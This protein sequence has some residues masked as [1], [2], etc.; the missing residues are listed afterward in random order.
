[1][2]IAKKL[3]K[4]N[5]AVDVV[6][7]AAEEENTAKLEAFQASSPLQSRMAHLTLCL[8]GS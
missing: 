7:L 6:S 8:S 4:N 2:K 5:V 1:M 3:K